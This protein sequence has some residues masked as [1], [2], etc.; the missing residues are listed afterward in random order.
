MNNKQTQKKNT[1]AQSG[2]ML[3]AKHSK[4]AAGSLTQQKT[5]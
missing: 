1:V 5:S 2:K 3:E 4:T